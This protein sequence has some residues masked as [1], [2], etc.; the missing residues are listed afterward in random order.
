[1]NYGFIKVAAAIPSVKVADCT[2]NVEQMLPIIK[3]AT[4]KNVSILLFPE[5]GITSYSCA[6]LFQQQLLTAPSTPKQ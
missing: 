3:E 6:D 2:Y 4:E 1:M 5:L